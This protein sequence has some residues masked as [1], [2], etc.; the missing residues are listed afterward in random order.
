MAK[1]KLPKLTL[2]EL[3]HNCEL[4]QD[5]IDDIYKRLKKQETWKEEISQPAT[6]SEYYAA[7]D[8]PEPD[9]E[10][11]RADLSQHWEDIKEAAKHFWPEL[12]ALVLASF[13][14]GA[15]FISVVR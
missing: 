14:A 3:Q 8:N 12:T 1:P 4:M 2:K 15:I 5:D 6:W 9:A 7:P 11:P 13:A 10:E